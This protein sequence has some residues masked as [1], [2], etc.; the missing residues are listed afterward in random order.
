VTQFALAYNSRNIVCGAV[1]LGALLEGP[2]GI[3]FERMAFMGEM[4]GC[5]LGIVPEVFMGRRDSRLDS[6]PG[7]GRIH[8]RPVG[9]SKYPITRTLRFSPPGLV[10]RRCVQ[11]GQQTHPVSTWMG[12]GRAS[13]LAWKLRKARRPLIRKGYLARHQ[14]TLRLLVET[15]P[16]DRPVEVIVPGQVRVRGAWS[17]TLSRQ[18]PPGLGRGQPEEPCAITGGLQTYRPAEQPA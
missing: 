18:K 5:C 8:W 13:L 4:P 7:R 3:G 6:R 10:R 9:C 1:E 15:R 14:E 11:T 2:S 12:D 17:V 16:G